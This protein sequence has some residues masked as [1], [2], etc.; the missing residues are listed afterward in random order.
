MDNNIYYINVDIGM[1][2]ISLSRLELH[3]KSIEDTIEGIDNEGAKTIVS[4]AYRSV[5]DCLKGSRVIT[6]DI[7]PDGFGII[8]PGISSYAHEAYL[9]DRCIVYNGIFNDAKHNYHA[10]EI[11]CLSPKRLDNMIFNVKGLLGEEYSQ[12]LQEKNP[13]VLDKVLKS[14]W[15]MI[16]VFSDD[17]GGIT[18]GY[19]SMR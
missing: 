12:L 14:D 6:E 15:N 2:W 1:E 5:N 9:H 16:R 11:A 10:V 8:H 7:I 13:R 4:A 18:T 3:S 19:F 17:A